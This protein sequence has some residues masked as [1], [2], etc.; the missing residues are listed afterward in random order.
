MAVQTGVEAATPHRLVQMLMEGALEKMAAARGH[1][2]RGNVAEKGAH[3]SWAIS[4]IEG[5]RASLDMEAGGEIARNLNDL[6]GYMGHRLLEAN[7]RNDAKALDEVIALLR[8]I[9]SGWD[10]IPGLL[11]QP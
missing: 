3:I 10:A 7:L 4:I 9:K 5:M 6:Y 8:E 2:Q 1:M 11:G